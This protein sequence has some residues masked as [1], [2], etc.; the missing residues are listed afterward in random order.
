MVTSSEQDPVAGPVP[1]PMEEIAKGPGTMDAAHSHAKAAAAVDE[2]DTG[3]AATKCVAVG[4]RTASA[5]GATNASLNIH[6]NPAVSQ[7]AN[8]EAELLIDEKAPDLAT[9]EN[10]VR[11]IGDRQA[12]TAVGP[13]PRLHL[14]S[15]MIKAGELDTIH[16]MEARNPA[17]SS[18]KEDVMLEV[19]ANGLMIFHLLRLR[20][21]AK[22]AEEAK[23]EDVQAAEAE[24]VR[25]AKA[26]GS[27]QNAEGD[28]A[29]AE[30]GSIT[31]MAK[32]ETS[33]S[34]DRSRDR[35]AKV[36]AQGLT[37]PRRMYNDGVGK[38]RKEGL[39]HTSCTCIDKGTP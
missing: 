22:A 33:Q 1:N 5:Q 34:Q 27:P 25:K 24:A 28:K 30:N 21:V 35:R 13:R 17:N 14:R 3:Q 2:A 23:A 12:G 7:G 4:V 39:R 16:L 36:D 20:K 19:N 10:P 31:I 38:E 6:Q 18:P 37:R 32:R 15:R 26:D 9:G 8:L 11:V 29:A